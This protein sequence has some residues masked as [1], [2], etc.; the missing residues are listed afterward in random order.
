MHGQ[1]SPVLRTTK[2]H[3]HSWLCLAGKHK[4]IREVVVEQEESSRSGGT[5]VMKG[6]GALPLVV[7]PVAV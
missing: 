1:S 6:L 2:D 3:F 5:E 7:K 4:V